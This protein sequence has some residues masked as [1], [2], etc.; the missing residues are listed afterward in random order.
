[1]SHYQSSSGIE[2]LLPFL[3]MSGRRDMDDL[4][5]MLLMMGNRGDSSCE[6]GGDESGDGST[7][8]TTYPSTFNAYL[9][10]LVGDNVRLTVDHPIYGATQ[11]VGKL[12]AVETDYLVLSNPAANGVPTSVRKIAIEISDLLAVDRV[13]RTEFLLSLLMECFHG[14]S[15]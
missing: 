11:I 7:S 2:Q 9:T 14:S 1:M 8:S 13:P 6:S 12:D 15:S 10:S 4:L 5:P 3:L